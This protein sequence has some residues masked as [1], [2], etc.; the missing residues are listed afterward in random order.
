M[1]TNSFIFK[2]ALNKHQQGVDQY[3]PDPERQSTISQTLSGVHL[4]DL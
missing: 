2:W 1:A 3:P 4:R